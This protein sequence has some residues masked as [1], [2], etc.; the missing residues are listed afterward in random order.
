MY[1]RTHSVF[2]NI[3]QFNTNNNSSL[4]LLTSYFPKIDPN[5]SEE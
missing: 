5:V 4:L 3:I 2:E 1:S